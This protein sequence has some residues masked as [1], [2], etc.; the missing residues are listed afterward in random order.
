MYASMAAAAVKWS[1]A[2]GQS[3]DE[4]ATN[5][6]KIAK[7]PVNAVR[8]LDQQLNFLTATQYEEI[9]ALQARGDS[10]RAAIAAEEAYAT[11][12]SQR[13]DQIKQNLGG[14]ETA[15]N[16]ISGAAKRAWDSMLDIGRQESPEQQLATAYKALASL[17]K[18]GENS[19]VGNANSGASALD[20]AFK[21]STEKAA[22]AA[23]DSLSAGAN[24]A[25]T[26]IERLGK[27]LED[28][29][30]QRAAA[31]ACGVYGEQQQTDYAK[32]RAGYE[33]Q[34]AD[35]REREAKK[36][37]PRPGRVS[38]RGVSEAENTFARLYGQYDPAAQAARA[39][40][41]EQGQLDLAFSKG[42]ISQEEYGMALAQASLN[43]AAAIKGAQGLTQA[44][45][46]RAQLER[47]LSA[48]RSEYSIAAAG[49]GMGDQ[50][51]QRM[52][53][54]VQLEQQANERILQLR[55][56]LANAT[57]EKQRQDLQAQIDLEQ[58]YLP[59]R[60]EALQSG[61]AQYDA[62]I[63]SPLNGWNAALANFQTSA[64]NVAGQTQ[65]LFSGAFGSIQTSV[66]SA[67]EAMTLGGQTFGQ[68]VTNVT[69]SLFG[70][71]VNSL[72][73][74]AA[75]W[76]VNQAMQLVFGQTSAAV[77]A[78][79]IAQAGAVTAAETSGAAAVAT[80]KVA[81]DG[82]TTASS[83]AATATVETAQVAAAGTTLAAWLPA[84]LVASVGSFGAAAIVGGTALLAAFALFKGFSTGGYV[85]GAVTG[86]SDSIP[87]RLS[88]GEFV[89]NAKA[90][91][92]NRELLEAINSNERVSFA[93][94]SVSVNAVQARGQQ[95]SQ[96]AQVN[97]TV[98]LVEDS[99]RAGTVQ[100][101]TRDDGSLEVE[102]FVADIYGGGERAQALE[103]AY[104]LRRQG[105]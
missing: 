52:Q 97:L 83:L 60:L 49:V 65:A 26:E 24:A 92:R 72:G 61:F 53:Q 15:W 100:Q 81:A 68:S 44:E 51:T 64:A 98:K 37:G 91:K 96:P 32:A 7:D 23:I 36:N 41:K 38:S 84:A 86:T 70:G 6:R 78:Q 56:E 1:S 42:K 34:I 50:Q 87:A 80:A 93:S 99:S 40:A 85:S 94:E 25:T 58:E 73:Q 74:M 27:Q 82:V 104:G 19:I 14:L 39:L 9:R 88:D 46:Y 66:G 4:V 13:A 76:G 29:D 101:T 90:T 75:Q 11:T 62:A 79:Q 3:I 59:K 33:K 35:I 10:Q 16:S 103:S 21:A 18:Q 67:F 5:F 77:A 55:T 69:R 71:V 28:L 30:K 105:T 22:K 89:V 95:P 2:T 17:N 54:R 102:A 31:I 20:T 45:Q 12:I 43:Y 57:T 47:Q 63:S 48:Q 8:E